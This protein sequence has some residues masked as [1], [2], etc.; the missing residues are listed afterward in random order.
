MKKVESKYCE[1]IR[2]I[3]G[4]LLGEYGV[5]VH[6][7]PFGEN[8][9]YDNLAMIEIDAHQNY[10]YRL[11]TLLH[12]AGHVM[13]RSSSNSAYES[14]KRQFPSMKVDN[15]DHRGNLDHRVDVLREEVIAWE[16]AATL[17]N[18]LKI[19]LDHRSFATHRNNCLK[20]YIKW[21]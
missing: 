20:S 13:L 17:S 18:Q 11:Y 3:E 7:V 8:A 19:D 15:R 10:K 2:R 6:Y 14:F 4:Y 21:T 1:Y 9:Y 12:E 5:E 16:K